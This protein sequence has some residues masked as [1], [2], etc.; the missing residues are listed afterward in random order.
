MDEDTTVKVVRRERRLAEED[1]KSGDV[2]M[3]AKRLRDVRTF[4]K[5]NQEIQMETSAH[6]DSA[7]SA[8]DQLRS[9]LEQT[10]LEILADEEPPTPVSDVHRGAT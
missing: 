5:L 4:A 8:G 3:A 9:G 7:E 1:A 2:A 10:F 6:G